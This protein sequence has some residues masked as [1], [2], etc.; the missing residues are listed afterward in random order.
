MFHFVVC[1]KFVSEYYHVSAAEAMRS[2]AFG[3]PQS[4]ILT[5]ESGSGKTSSISHILSYFF[6]SYASSQT[7]ERIGAA[8]E[9][10]EMFG[11]AK[12]CLNENSSRFTKLTKVGH[13]YIHER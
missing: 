13:I 10:I 3:K 8:Y 5:G 12:T 1:V 4:I 6:N 7:N 11:N 2:V 9:L